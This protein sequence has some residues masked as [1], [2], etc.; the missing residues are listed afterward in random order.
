MVNA[1][2]DNS[3]KIL[4]MLGGCPSTSF[5]ENLVFK[6]IKRILT[7]ENIPFKTDTYGNIL[8]RIE[9]KKPGNKP[10]AFV[11]HMDH[12]GF[13]VDRIENGQVI[14]KALGG[15]PIA[16]IKKATKSFSF[17]EKTGDR[18]LCFLEPAEHIGGREV[19]VN[20]DQDIEIGSPIVFDLP[21]FLVDEELIRMRA[22]DDL[23]GCAAIMCGLIEWNRKQ[24][25]SHVYAAF[26]RAEE[27][28]LI[29]ARLLAKDTFLTEET[30]VISV[31]TSSVIPGVQLGGGPV[32][33]TGDASYTFDFEAEN[34]L[35]SAKERILSIDS[36]FKSQRQLMNAG[37]CEAG[38]FMANGYKSSG[39]AFPLGNWHNATTYIADPDGGV[40]L[41]YIS[42]DDFKGGVR[43]ILEAPYASSDERY[44]RLGE[45]YLDVPSDLVD[46]LRN[47]QS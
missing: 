47:T 1:N 32:I 6:C 13:E 2:I 31:E 42:L 25:D 34:V 17:D 40:D 10:V 26:T 24:P 18:N 4:E 39:I 45:R 36:G 15:V 22:M 41:E 46:R 44:L 38:A 33:R 8:V 29:G 12:P 43:L 28:G 3:L 37:S 19:L 21:D 30:L 16:S 5:H 11:A 9:G 27:V 20:S 14:A 23:G 7:S 35:A